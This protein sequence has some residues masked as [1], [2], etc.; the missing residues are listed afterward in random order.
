MNSADAKTTPIFNTSQGGY[1]GVSMFTN[2]SGH[3]DIGAS[4]DSYPSF[5]QNAIQGTK[6]R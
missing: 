4:P 5:V 3:I 2:I 6:R 1:S